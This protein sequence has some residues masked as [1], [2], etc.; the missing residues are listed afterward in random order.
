LNENPE[1]FSFGHGLN[2]GNGGWKAILAWT[3]IIVKSEC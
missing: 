2:L 3:E 1:V